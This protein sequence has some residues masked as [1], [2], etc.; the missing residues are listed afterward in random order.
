MVTA[1]GLRRHAHNPKFFCKVAEI[2]ALACL[3]P[4]V[5]GDDKNR[6]HAFVQSTL[7]P[8][9]LIP[10]KPNTLTCLGACIANTPII[11]REDMSCTI[12]PWV[13]TLTT[14]G[15]NRDPCGA[16]RSQFIVEQDACEKCPHCK[17]SI[18]NEC[19]RRCTQMH[20]TGSNTLVPCPVCMEDIPVKWVPL[21]QLLLTS[22]CK[23]FFSPGDAR[24]LW[25]VTYPRVPRVAKR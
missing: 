22:C 24:A 6:L 7:T 18:C 17:S 10:P 2:S 11:Q 20:F 12:M 3:H 16:C 1:C 15:S 21:G 5:G 4:L 9:T 8:Q 25:D 23:L 19:T 14:V 13:G